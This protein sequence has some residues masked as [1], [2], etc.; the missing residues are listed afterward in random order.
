[1]TACINS[2]V[3]IFA[4]YSST[5]ED[6]PEIKAE[7]DAETDAEGELAGVMLLK[8]MVSPAISGTAASIAFV[9]AV[10]PASESSCDSEMLVEIMPR[11]H[12]TVTVSALL[13][14]A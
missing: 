6:G 7:A 9:I 1:M 11:T 2:D 8:T 4:G 14:S 3:S 10:R 13:M 5:S 12:S